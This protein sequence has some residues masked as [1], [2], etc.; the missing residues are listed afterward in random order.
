MSKS[1]N[2]FFK[3][4]CFLLLTNISSANISGI[5]FQDLPLNGDVLNTYGS[6]DSNELGV[7]NITVTA[8]PENSST[9]TDING[10]WELNTTQNSRIEFSNFPSYLKA[11]PSINRSSSVQFIDDNTTNVEFGLHN[12]NDYT[13][14]NNP[15]YVNNLQQNGTHIGSV[16]Q[17]LHTIHYQSTGLNANYRTYTG[18]TDITAEIPLD[19]I[20]MEE[21]GSV[22]GKAYQKNKKRLFVS[23]MLQRHIGFAKGADYVYMVDYSVNPP[24]LLG[25][26]SLEGETPDNGGVAIQL[27]NV[28]RSANP[29]YELPIDP[30]SPNIDID[31]YAKVGKISYGGIDIDHNNNKLWLINLNQRGIISLDISNEINNSNLSVNQYLIEDFTNV[32]LCQNGTLRPWAMKTHND[33]GYIG[34][35]CDANVSGNV[36]DMFAY[37]LSFDLNITN[38]TLVFT[39]EL[40]FPLNYQRQLKGWQ[41]WEDVFSYP[42]NQG[43]RRVHSQPILSDIEFDEHQNMYIAFIDRYATQVASFNYSAVSGSTAVEKA[44]NFGEVLKVCYINGS[45]EKE[46][47]GN[48]M[49]SNFN[50]LNISEFFN[51]NGGDA[52]PEAS[53]GSLALLQG[54][55]EILVSLLDPHPQAGT[56][57]SNQDYWYTQGVQ[58]LSLNDGKI[59]NWYAHAYTPTQG[60]NGKANG[61]GDVEFI[62]DAA[63]I[64]IGNRIWLDSDGNGIQD[65]NET[66]ISGVKIELVCN[67][68]TSTATTNANGN[69]IFSNDSSNN[70]PSD[71][72]HIY[73]IAGLTEGTNNCFLLIPNITG[74]SQQNSLK[75]HT[76]TISAVG[77]G[78]NPTL[79]DSNASINGINAKITIHALDIRL[80]GQNNHSFDIGFTSTLPPVV[81]PPVIVPP[82]I[83]PPSVRPPVIVPPVVNSRYT[84]GNRVWLDTNRNGIQDSNETGI[85][86]I[87]VDLYNNTNCTGTAL[88]STTTNNG[89]Y[90]FT[91]LLG[92]DYCVAFSTLP[93]NH[94]IS[95]ANQGS[96]DTLDSD[97]NADAQITN[98][99]LNDNNDTHDMG[100]YPNT[101]TTVLGTTICQEMIIHN[102]IQPANDINAITTI[103]VFNNDTGSKAGQEIKFLSLTEG[104]FLWENNE[105]DISSA[106]TL[107]TLT[108]A[109]E[110]TWSVVD[111]KVVFTALTSFDGQIPTP[112]YYIIKGLDCTKAT[113]LSNV[114]QIRINAPC[115]CPTYDTKSVDTINLL[116]MLLLIL[117][118]STITLFNIKKEL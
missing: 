88:A 116:S 60:L 61:I 83:I 7:P 10:T 37:V 4:F 54:S 31:A 24:E 35:I 42:G 43:G 114:A 34:A 6:K 89:L 91:N 77:E 36:N 44:Y 28:N 70:V 30:L 76:L 49:Q 52:N 3:L 2:I 51:D 57:I 107:D 73:D 108:V 94:N 102:D 23:S 104:K 14:T 103:D 86:G 78:N 19:T 17:S 100:I 33:K 95:S 66:G 20:N 82:V 93:S 101:L 68:I 98:I 21:I 65:A 47:T 55:N 85:N 111:N 11:S 56:G 96:N 74:A 25:D 80:S 39:E 71:A 46:G 117:L 69:Y 38:S 90:Q 59:K 62:T 99:D 48:C 13:N 67:G 41:A 110:G 9:I 40:S 105:Q 115:Y 72:S 113:Q 79:N 75:N 12:I 26:F 112:I 109:G 27:G 63:P 15:V 18:L 97:A 81:I 50:D 32:P 58:T 45:Y 16:T 8:Y 118:T 1:N 106:T 29:D 5:V 22:W 64:E 87:S 92:G 84:L 53:L